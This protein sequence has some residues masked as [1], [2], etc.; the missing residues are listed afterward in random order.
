MWVYWK[1]IGNWQAVSVFDF[2]HYIKSWLIT[3]KNY[4]SIN[5]TISHVRTL[6][7]TR[8]NA[9]IS[10]RKKPFLW[11]ITN[12]YRQ[13][14]TATG[15]GID[16]QRFSSFN[17]NQKIINQWKKPTKWTFWSCHY[18]HHHLSSSS[19]KPFLFFSI[20]HD[21]LTITA[22]TF[23]IQYFSNQFNLLQI[24]SNLFQMKLNL[25]QFIYRIWFVL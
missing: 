5:A 20:K 6:H 24:N 10:N 22:F 21:T 7:K 19:S 23:E 25:F 13:R 12:A 17:S 11:Y 16:F 9:G 15:P 3:N 1:V 8:T 2:W 14:W 4:P 18:R